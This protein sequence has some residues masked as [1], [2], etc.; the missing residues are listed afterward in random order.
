M[1]SVNGS[2]GGVPLLHLFGD[3]HQLLPVGRK[4]HFDDG[5]PTG[6]PQEADSL[7]KAAFQLFRNLPA[8]SAQEV[9]VAVVMDETIR[10]TDPQHKKLIHELHQ[11]MSRESAE[12]LTSRLLD[13]FLPAEQEE[14]MQN[15]LCAMPAWKDT[16]PIAKGHLKSLNQPVA[17]VDAQFSSSRSK[18][19][20][21]EELNLPVCAAFFS[22]CKGDVAD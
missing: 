17:R 3:C 21:K 12:L 19:H 4:C 10:Q 16:I 5:P 18:N 11:G 15:A 2:G 8:D 13:Q 6:E 7:G 9:A 1:K 14:F 20:A 22:R